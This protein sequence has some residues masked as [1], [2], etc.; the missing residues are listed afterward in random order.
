MGKELYREL[1]LY[2]ALYT[3]LDT[4]AVSLAAGYDL[5]PIGQLADRCENE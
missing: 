4:L 3:Q 5:P 1:G 2:L